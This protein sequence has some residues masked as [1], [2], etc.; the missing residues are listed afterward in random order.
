MWGCVPPWGQG[1]N[2]GKEPVTA[3]QPTYVEGENFEFADDPELEW[4][5]IMEERLREEEE[6]EDESTTTD[7]SAPSMDPYVKDGLRARRKKNEEKQE[8]IVTQ[9]IDVE[10][11][12]DNIPLEAFTED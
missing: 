10:D 6:A 1:W 9:S 2:R 11:I 5:R 8:A 7:Q 3:K 4:L 12:F